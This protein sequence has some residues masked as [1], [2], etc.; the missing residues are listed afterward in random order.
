MFQEFLNSHCLNIE[1]IA[2]NLTHSC[3]TFYSQL[4]ML[5]L[6]LIVTLIT[7]CASKRVYEGFKVYDINVR[8]Q[9]DLNL[10]KNLDSNEGERRE[11]DFLSLHNN[12]ND[13]ARVVVK[14]SEQKFIEDYFRKNKLDYEVRSDNIQE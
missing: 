6:F 14:P 3:L 1:V 5:K 8:N 10:L 11:L 2:F 13:V 7:L 9:N 4:I 12:V